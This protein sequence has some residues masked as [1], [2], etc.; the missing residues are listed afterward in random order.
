MPPSLLPAPLATTL[1]LMI[2]VHRNQDGSFISICPT[3]FRTIAA[4]RQEGDLISCEKKHACSSDDLAF[5]P[6]FGCN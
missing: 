5:L 2:F 3:C 6:K 1:P 4:A